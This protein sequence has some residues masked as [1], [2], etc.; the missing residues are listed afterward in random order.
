MYL[1]KINVDDK[2]SRNTTYGS[3]VDCGEM[4]KLFKKKI[5]R[6]EL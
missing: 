1:K 2:I 6:A 4:F 3:S 5:W